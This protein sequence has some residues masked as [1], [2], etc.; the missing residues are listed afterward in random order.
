MNGFLIFYLVLTYFVTSIPF[1]YIIGK[2]FGKDVRREGSGNIGATNVARTVG[3]IPGLLV[4]ILDAL[5]G[6]IPVY[7]ATKY[8]DLYFS[9]KDI[10]LI[11]IFAILGHCFSIF[12]KFKGGKGVATGLGVLFALSFKSA[13][14]TL[15]LW[16]GIFLVSGYVSLASIL[17]ATISGFFVFGNTMNPVYSLATFI[18]SFII[19][20][21]HID[22]IERLL[23]GKEHKFLHKC[24]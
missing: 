2:I 18:S 21:K 15:A 22:N 16:L 20:V 3:K 24:K 14:L 6:F 1:G 12:M 4:L 19:V 7:Y 11:A 13:M 9:P 10:G 5:K 17:A 23:S 8:F